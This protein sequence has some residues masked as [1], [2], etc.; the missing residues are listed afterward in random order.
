MGTK[1]DICKQ[2][3]EFFFFMELY[4]IHVCDTAKKIK[5]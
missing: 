4:V 1:A 2:E 3:T 5:E